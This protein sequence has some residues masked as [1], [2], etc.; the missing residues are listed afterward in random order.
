MSRHTKMDRCSSTAWKEEFSNKT[1]AVTDDQLHWPFLTRPNHAKQPFP[2]TFVEF[3]NTVMAFNLRH[4]N[5]RRQVSLSVLLFFD[6]RV[7][8]FVIA[9]FMST[10]SDFFTLNRS[11]SSVTKRSKTLKWS[12]LKLRYSTVDTRREEMG[13]GGGYDVW[14]FEFQ[15]KVRCTPNDLFDILFLFYLLT[16]LF[17]W[18]STPSKVS[19]DLLVQRLLIT[20]ATL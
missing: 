1:S 4:E 8:F 20:I 9:F 7:C 10:E 14:T 19:T 17:L 11:H 18:S 3:S 6:S 12:T 15:A 2:I 16:V 5:F 13:R